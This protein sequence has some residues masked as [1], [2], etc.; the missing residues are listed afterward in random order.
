[1]KPAPATTIDLDRLA[2]S[3]GE[4]RRLGLP[5]LLGSLALGSQQYRPV[6]EAVD[7]T[8]SVSRTASGHAFR[9]SFG[10]R[11][12][13]PCMRCLLDAGVDLEVE[14][15]EV[16]QPS[17]DD[18]ELTSPYVEEGML[19]VGR[20]AHDALVLATPAQI[21]CREDCPGLCAVCGERLEGADPADHRHDEGGDPRWAKLRDLEVGGGDKG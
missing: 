17:T 21:L 5:I 8:L 16:D 6:P 9:L 2:L 7:A 11:L 18:E 13:G 3:H 15:R 20:W 19:E 1:M 10:V 14:A 12:E 4:G